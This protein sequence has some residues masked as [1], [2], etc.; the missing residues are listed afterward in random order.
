MNKLLYKIEL[1]L[2]KVIPM[3][4]AL[5]SLLN[6]TLSYFD[7][8]TVILSYIGSVSFITLLFLYITS[9][10]F[11]FCEYHRMFIHYTTITWILNIID[12]YIGIPV[13]DIWYLGIQL[14]VAGISLFI[15][16]YLYVKRSLLLKIVN[17]IDAG[18]SNITEG[19]A[20]EIVDSLK[21][22]TDK[23]KRLSKYAACEYLNV[24]RAIFDNYVR[25]GKL[26][27]GKHEAGF[28]ELSWDKKTLDEFIRRNKTR[29]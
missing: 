13:S 29:N 4:Y 28:K 27:R 24:S 11:K 22:F 7:I 15:I 21:R 1:Y 16:L 17:D 5:L 26:P 6:T 20:M 23:E 8:N 19:E 2:V 25:E 3:I 10:V 12:L 14:I 18:N 9:Y